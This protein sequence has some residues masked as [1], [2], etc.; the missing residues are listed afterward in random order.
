M[1]VRAVQNAIA[2][3]VGG[4]R[5]LYSFSPT[6][7][8]TQQ[9]LNWDD[10]SVVR[11]IL[12]GS[13]GISREY[14]QRLRDRRLLKR[15]YLKDI[16]SVRDAL[17]RDRM[18]KLTTADFADVE[19]KIAQAL[20][21]KLS[22]KTVRPEFVIA[23]LLT[24]DNPT[25][26]PPGV[27]IRTND[28]IIRSDDGTIANADNFPG[29]IIGNAAEENLNFMSVYAAMDDIDDEKRKRICDELSGEIT[30][31]LESA[32]GRSSRG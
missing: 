28:I 13:T 16:G 25:F 4:I 18:A 19:T 6:K 11:T 31:I 2:E 26:R 15:I 10:E 30:G 3:G 27:E 5:E 1:F 8:F 32:G 22:P 9:F 7:E 21:R 14:I 12:D 23:Y 24:I 20:S 29:S 17:V